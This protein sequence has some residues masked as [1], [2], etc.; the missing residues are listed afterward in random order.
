MKDIQEL[1][2]LLAAKMPIVAIESRDEA[3]VLQMFER[4]TMLN[5]RALWTWSVT[6]GLQKH[7]AKENAYNT[8]KI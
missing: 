7:N 8:T 2:G 3:K 6:S 1:E 4:F 5:E